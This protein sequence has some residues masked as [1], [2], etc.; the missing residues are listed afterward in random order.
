MLTL[1]IL[2]FGFVLGISAIADKDAFAWV[3]GVRDTLDRTTVRMYHRMI[4]VG[5]LMLIMTGL[6]LFYPQ[7]AYLLGNL[8]FDIKLLFVAILGLNALL[9]GR[10]M[11]HALDNSYAELGARD[12]RA[13]FASGAVSVFAWACAAGIAFYMFG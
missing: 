7:R 11:E 10:L 2:S 8:L 1:H 9:I 13:L 12:K 3:R 6:I 4:W 5:L